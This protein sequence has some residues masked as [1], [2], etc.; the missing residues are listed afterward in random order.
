MLVNFSITTPVGCPGPLEQWWV[1]NPAGVWS[2]VVPY[3]SGNNAYA[4]HTNGLPD[5]T[6]QV[7]VWAKQRGSTKSYEAYSFVTYTLYSGAIDAAC[8][9]VNVSAD[10]SSPTVIGATVNLTAFANCDTPQYKWWV[11]DPAG[12]WTVVKDY[13]STATYAWATTGRVAG[14]YQLGVWARQG[15]SAASYQAYSFMTLTLI[16]PQPTNS[17]CNFVNVL[18]GMASPEPPGTSIYFTAVFGGCSVPDFQ[19]WV[20]PPGGTWTIVQ[21]YGPS[22]QYVW[23]TTGLSPGPWEIGVWVR[24]GGSK[25]RYEAFAFTTF[26]LTFG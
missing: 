15:G 19:F 8:H 16:N 26:Q 6:Y 5:G 20:L 17:A 10:H 2:I 24:Q 23:D 3:A 21:P 12:H 18:P 25:A 9:S 14:T 7:G 13:S 1:R 4:W 11:R 22:N